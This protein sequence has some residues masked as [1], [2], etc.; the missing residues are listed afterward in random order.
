MDKEYSIEVA[1]G[2]ERRLREE[3]PDEKVILFGARARGD[4]LR[5]S[6]FDYI[7][8]SNYFEGIYFY[9]RM[10]IIYKIWDFE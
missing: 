1:R 7:I 6:D 2:F 3:I 8:V 5:D 10:P 4:N 9:K